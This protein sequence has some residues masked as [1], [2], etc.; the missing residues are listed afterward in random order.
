MKRKT[1]IK[2]LLISQIVPLLL[3]LYEIQRKS[4]GYFTLLEYISLMELTFLL[5]TLIFITYCRRVGAESLKEIIKPQKFFILC[6]VKGLSTSILIILIVLLVLE[7]FF[8][9]KTNFDIYLSG[10]ALI[11]PFATTFTAV[12]Q[13]NTNKS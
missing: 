6:L 8:P 2:M 7:S 3:L 9:L 11:S 1:G 13:L 12:K 10:S 4:V 5:P